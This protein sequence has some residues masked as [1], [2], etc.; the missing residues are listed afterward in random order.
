MAPW[1]L[2]LAVSEMQPRTLTDWGLLAT[3]VALW[4]SNFMFVKLGVATVPPATLAAG[5]LVV[6]AAVLVV[7]IRALGYPFPRPSRMWIPYLLLAV[8]GNSLPFWLI[9][10]G[11]QTIDSALAGILMAIM[12]LATLVMAHL[13]VTGEHMTRNRVLGFLLGFAGIVVL[14]GPAALAGLG[15]SAARVLAQLA[16]LGGALCYATQSVLVRVT[17]KG[18]VMVA[19]AAIITI[20]AAVSLPIALLVDQPW[21]LAP[22]ATSVWAVIWMGVGPTA[23]ATLAFIRLIGSA[24]PTFMSLVNYC[25][26]V[27]AVLIGVAV[28]GETP[29]AN[30]YAG[31]V[32]ILAGI[33]VT[34]LRRRSRA[35]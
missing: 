21:T 6:G 32:L 25:V 35:P 9:S 10:W 2:I 33:A 28:L 26:P 14:M 27:V 4:G 13:W 20:A 30:A 24:G 8:V 31:L 29:N 17:L 16:V 5:R 1:R 18:D 15:G 19:S 3:L 12:P 7:V 23:I 22:S 34:Q 11:Q